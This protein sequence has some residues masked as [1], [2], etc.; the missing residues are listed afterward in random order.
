MTFFNFWLPALFI[1][2]LV[3]LL[4]AQTY[5]QVGWSFDFQRADLF[6]FMVISSALWGA[7]LLMV[8][9]RNLSLRL[10][11]SSTTLVTNQKII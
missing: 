1:I 8:L 3:N 6:F 2:S 11:K 9:M 10:L 5:L 4:L 7:S